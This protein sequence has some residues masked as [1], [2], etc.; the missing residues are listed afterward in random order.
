[1]TTTP[2]ID[3]LTRAVKISE[4]IAA[5]QAEMAAIFGNST[6]VVEAAPEPE[7]ADGRKRKRSAATIAKMRASQKK[8]WAKVKAPVASKAP[9]LVKKKR[10]MSAAGRAA[11][12]AAQ[13]ARWAKI[14]AGV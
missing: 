3:Q 8:R 4:Q 6:P 14:K 13:K 5:L 7:K 12:A 11:I 2:T 10:K 1:M 9:A